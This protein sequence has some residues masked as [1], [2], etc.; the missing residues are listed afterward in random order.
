MNFSPRASKHVIVAAMKVVSGAKALMEEY[1][2]L[3][4]LLF[5][6]PPDDSKIR[7]Q[8]QNKRL[9]AAEDPQSVRDIVFDLIIGNLGR[10]QVRAIIIDKDDVETKHRKEEWLYE[11][12][13]FYLYRSILDRSGWT[14]TGDNVQ[15]LID[16]TEDKRMKKATFRGVRNAEALVAAPLRSTVHHVSS[17]HHPFLQL[18][19]Y[20]CW[21]IYRKY[22]KEDIRSYELIKEAVQ[23]EWRLYKK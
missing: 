18:A 11:N 14:S 2:R 22:E 17:F 16:L 3:R 10:M 6:T 7:H 13:Y 15:L 9:H 5:T 4:H 21:A 1:W 23:D 19:D 20:F 8:F 12:L